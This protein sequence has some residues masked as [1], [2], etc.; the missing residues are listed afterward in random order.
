MDVLDVSDQT[1]HDVS[2]ETEHDVSDETEEHKVWV[3]IQ[4]SAHPRVYKGYDSIYDAAFDLSK[5]EVTTA[6]CTGCTFE[7]AEHIQNNAIN[8]ILSKVNKA[9]DSGKNEC[10]TIWGYISKKKPDL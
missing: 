3:V 7:K 6:I 10:H 2:D 1:K 8:Q 9:F 4:S 5:K